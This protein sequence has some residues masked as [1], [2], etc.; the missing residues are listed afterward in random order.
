[1]FVFVFT[2]PYPFYWLVAVFLAIMIP[3]NLV[4]P[5]RTPGDSG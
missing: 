4:Y 2:R 3:L 1:V 5:D